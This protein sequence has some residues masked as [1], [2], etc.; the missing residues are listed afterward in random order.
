MQSPP[1]LVFIE[2]LPGSGKSTAAQRLAFEG[3]RQGWATRW[4]Y[5]QDAAHPL[6]GYFEPR[7]GGDPLQFMAQARARWHT[8]ASNATAGTHLVESHLF[9]GPIG[10]LLL[11]AVPP[12]VISAFVSDLMQA[13]TPLAPRLIRL[14]E[15]DA[16]SALGRI[17]AFRWDSLEDNPYIRRF[18]ASPYAHAHGLHGFSGYVAFCVAC[19]DLAQALAAA[20]PWPVL[21]VPA[22]TDVAAQRQRL[23]T[24][25]DYLGMSVPLHVDEDLTAFA[26]EYALPDGRR[27]TISCDAEGLLVR[28]HPRL[29][30]AGNR[31][32]QRAPARFLVVS[33]PFDVVF[34]NDG[35]H[36]VAA[37]TF[38]DDQGTPCGERFQRLHSMK[39]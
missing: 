39:S 1:R 38:A 15:A 28:G 8:F 3:G 21:E 5:E 23:A 34:E 29:W 35:E 25:C 37:M 30:R 17:I 7:Q 11:Q 14:V 9:Q 31:L 13:V 6:A 10:S 4:Y 22:A 16:S 12:H 20:M 36:G 19:A 33:W 32:L 18:D 24:M 2:G 26:G 27:F